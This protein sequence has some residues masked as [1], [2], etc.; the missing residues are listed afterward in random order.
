M[1]PLFSLFVFLFCAHGL[2][3]Q[4]VKQKIE[5]KQ[6][7]L[8]LAPNI[9][10]P[11]EDAGYTLVLP[12]E[13]KAKGLIV[14]FNSDRDTINKI[15][16]HSLPLGIAVA[17]VSTGN[18]FEFFFEE[19]QM[20]QIETYLQEIVTDYKIPKRNLLF[21][22]M[23]LAGTRALK[24]AIFA[25]RGNSRFG[26]SP[27][28]LA[29]C[30]SP[31]DFVRFWQSL[32]RAKR[33]NYNP[34]AVNEATWVTAYLEKNLGGTPKNQEEA[35]I[36]YSPYSFSNLEPG[37]ERWLKDIA[38]RTYTEP[39]VQW[40][41]ENRGKSYYGMNA[42]DAAAL[43]NAL[44]LLGNQEADL[45]LTENKGYRPDGSRHPHSWSIVDEK[46][47]VHWFNQLLE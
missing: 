39:D 21:C 42:L 7:L 19:K 24:Q 38:V 45:I 1:R 12:Q 18:R 9:N 6:G 17:Y 15:F 27:R 33:L 32:E 20:Q 30:D 14:F 4:L 8:Q 44:R 11:Y 29:T 5:P 3:A 31:I 25:K 43:I 2:A 41:M 35:F 36:S 10:V 34:I 23:S 28:A 16:H 46:E 37:N 47:L 13:E 22:G 40:W 26:L